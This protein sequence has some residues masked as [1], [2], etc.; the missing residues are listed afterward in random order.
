[1]DIQLFQILKTRSTQLGG[2]RLIREYAKLGVIGPSVKTILR[3]PL[4]R[5]T[6]KKVYSIAL[7][8]VEPVLMSR[9][10]PLM[11]K[12]KAFYST[13]ALEH[14][15]SNIIWFCWL[16]GL[17][18]APEIVKVCYASLKR[19]LP[20]REIKIVDENNWRVYVDMPDYII[21]RRRK[22]HIPPAHFSDLLRLQL[23]IQ[24]GGT[25]IDSTV[26]CTGR[27]HTKEYLDAD[28]FM[29]QYTRPGSD[30]WGGIGNWFITA[31]SNNEVLMV[32]R[33]M[34]FAYWKDYNCTLD[35]YIFHL[36]FSML[37]GV[38]PN[39]INAMPYG[40]AMRHIALVHHWGVKFDQEKWDK[41]V[42]KVNFHK[43]AYY[44]DTDVKKRKDNYYHYILSLNS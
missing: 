10:A 40:Y 16:Q 1:M 25:W 33:D 21:Q 12:R 13:Q 11:Q 39:Q 36:F 14:N 17:D 15:R 38:Y 30:Q 31:C 2:C 20:D 18:K 7:H 6:F 8:K 27:E 26:L 28:L 43:L 9:Y 19:Y 37:R 3:K 35:Y 44:V 32:L 4:S 24:Y 23:L 5:Q 22:K 34:L 41:L 42:N 29:F